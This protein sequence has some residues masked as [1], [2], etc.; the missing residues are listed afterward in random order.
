MRTAGHGSYTSPMTSFITSTIAFFVAGYFIRRGLDD[1]DI[2]KTFTR[3]VV[4]FVLALMVAYAAAALV[5]RL[6]G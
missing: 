2:P 6:V 1:H 5:D 3:T 4:I